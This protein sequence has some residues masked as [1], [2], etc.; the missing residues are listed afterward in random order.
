MEKR[1][2]FLLAGLT[3]AGITSLVSTNAV[4]AIDGSHVKIG[5]LIQTDAVAYSGDR[6][7]DVNKGWYD[8][9]NSGADIRRIS[10]DVTGELDDVWSYQIS[11]DID[12]TEWDDTWLGFGGFEPVWLAIGRISPPQGLENWMGANVTHFMEKADVAQ[13]FGPNNGVGLYGEGSTGMV[14]YAAAIFAPDHEAQYDTYYGNGFEDSDPI[15]ASL[16][17]TFA[18]IDEEGR[19]VHLGGSVAY[20]SIDNNQEDVIISTNT[21]FDVRDQDS[22]IES[23]D[24]GY[25]YAT[26]EANADSYDVAGLEAGGIFGP[27]SGQ[28]EYQKMFVQG[29]GARDNLE[30]SGWYAQAAYVLT[31]ESRTYEQASGTFGNV[32]PASNMGA[33]EVALRYSVLDLSDIADGWYDDKN[34]HRGKQS[35]WTAGVNWYVNEY[36]KF[37]ANYVRASATYSNDSNSNVDDRDVNGVGI[38]AQVAF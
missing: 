7:D 12:E 19:V 29:T 8:Q 2:Q 37:Q 24:L 30:F 18:P 10:I 35:D 15:G 32:Y 1:S 36:V 14:S 28:A 31:G 25:D 6:E 34:D 5:G 4:A 26:G 17:L 22:L 11:Y 3:L 21:G 33:W 38:R 9:F 13:A 16:R 27:L 20:Q 23:L